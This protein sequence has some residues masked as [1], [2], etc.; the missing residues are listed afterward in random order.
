MENIDYL[1]LWL[2]VGL[3]YDLRYIKDR[4]KE[5]IELHDYQFIDWFWGIYIHGSMATCTDSSG[6]AGHSKKSL[7]SANK[8]EKY[9][10]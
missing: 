10:I 3:C 7:C 1:L 4:R 8:K 2:V 5:E 9:I 6:H